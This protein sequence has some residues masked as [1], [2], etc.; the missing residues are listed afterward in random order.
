MIRA[1]SAGATITGTLTPGNIPILT[2]SGIEDSGVALLSTLPSSS[3][4]VAN[5]AAL[6]ALGDRPA[7]VSVSGY[8][9]VNDGGGGLWQ[10]VA[11]STT[12]ADDALVVNPTS[13]TAGRYKRLYDGALNAK[14]FGAVGDGVTDD[15]AALQAWYAVG[16]ALVIPAGTYNITAVLSTTVA[17]TNLRGLGKVTIATG[18]AMTTAAIRAWA[19][20]CSIE[21]INIDASASA[22]ITDGIHIAGHRYVVRDVTVTGGNYKPWLPGTYPG[23]Y[24]NLRVAGPSST[25]VMYEDGVIDN[26]SAVRGG[27]GAGLYVVGG[28]RLQYSNIRAF[29]CAGWGAIVGGGLSVQNFQLVN[30]EAVSCGMYG[31]SDS[32]QFGATGVDPRA[33]TDWSIV[34]A[35][36]SYCGWRS[37]LDG[38]YGAIG[39]GKFG[40]DIT[41]GSRDGFYFRGGARDCCVGG[42]ELKGGDFGVYYDVTK[43][44]SSGTAS[45]TTLNFASTSTVY[46]GMAVAGT[47]I[48]ADTYIASK[49]S[50]TVVLTRAVSGAVS[51]GASIV[52]TTGLTPSG[53]KNANVDFN[54]ISTNGNAGY[55]QTGLYA[56]LEDSTSDQYFAEKHKL[57]AFSTT[58]QAVSWRSNLRRQPYEIMASNGL[59]WLCMGA[60]ANGQPGTTGQ[61]APSS[62]GRYVKRATNAVQPSPTVLQFASVTDISAGMLV[63]G[64]NIPDGTYVQ[65][66]DGGALTATLTQATTGSGVANGANVIIAS[67]ESD[68]TMYWMCLGTDTS[69][70]ATNRNIGAQIN[71]ASKIELEVSSI[72]CGYGVYINSNRGVADAI[73]EV[74]VRAYV[75]DAT[76]GISAT[77]DGV[78]TNINLV[79][80]D[81]DATTAVYLFGTGGTNN[82]NI[83][84]GRITNA[85]N[86][87]ALR[88]SDGT[89]NVTIDGGA[90][91]GSTV[92][93]T[94]YAT[95]GTNTIKIGS[96]TI[97]G[98]F[99]GAPMNDVI[100]ASTTLEVWW[101][102]AVLINDNTSNQYGAW[103]ASGGATVTSHGG[104]FR[105]DLTTDPNTGP[106]KGQVGEHMVL[107]T[108]T[109]TVWG[110]VCTVKDTTWKAK[111]LA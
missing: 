86:G 90:Y 45:G 77:G 35:M 39:S 98:G 21:N 80:C 40:Y 33:L 72:G 34:N 38:K 66:V 20:D 97:Q 10:W 28:R 107:D 30:F 109:A 18:A 44:T 73:N 69:G 59:S 26:F 13:G 5:I 16:G 37:A 29:G 111:T 48:P 9:S 75:R 103:N 24:Y 104:P 96:A 93:R 92:G 27:A 94:I 58:K 41:S 78:N 4:S 54:Y 68:G 14:W 1:S 6:K 101:G 63:L 71:C 42:M 50:T 105:R 56:L 36:V 3:Y 49:T 31:F 106:K 84:G 2:A 79:G 11:G 12:T 52:F 51:S 87:A 61:T 43:T 46:V 76:Y 83:V 82:V 15:T 74:T 19:D 89:N 23:P 62:A 88:L 95:S 64:T 55:G 7:M 81:V 25:Y 85:A 57:R 70:L 102:N 100:G 22:S 60:V 53:H 108:P 99:N 65:S 91:V 8:T 67:L 17:G 110:Y 47:N 32:A